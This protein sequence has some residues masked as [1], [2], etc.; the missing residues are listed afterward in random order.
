MQFKQELNLNLCVY[1]DGKPYELKISFPMKHMT[2]KL[3]QKIIELIKKQLYSSYLRIEGP[4]SH[5]DSS[6]S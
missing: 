4:S 6:S 1:A 3:H 2:A 5:G